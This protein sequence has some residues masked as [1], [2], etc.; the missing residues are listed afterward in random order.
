MATWRQRR[1]ARYLGITTRLSG[2]N[3]RAFRQIERAIGW[4]APSKPR[5]EPK[6]LTPEQELAKLKRQLKQQQK[7]QLEQI[8]A[9][10]L[11]DLIK[12]I[13]ERTPEELKAMVDESNRKYILKLALANL[14]LLGRYA[15]R[16]KAG[17]LPKKRK[18]REKKPIP[19]GTSEYFHHRYM[20]RKGYIPD[21]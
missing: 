15:L 7:E 14:M 6:I 1:Y 19:Y 11:P 18:L 3:S 21:D 17:L 20:I 10:V 13:S 4:D 12:D 16:H 2:S 8:K 9:A 5:K